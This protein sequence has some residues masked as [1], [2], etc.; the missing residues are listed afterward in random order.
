M[1]MRRNY[2]LEQLLFAIV[3]TLFWV[4]VAW[5]LGIV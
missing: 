1:A 3:G 4:L 2:Q 5:L